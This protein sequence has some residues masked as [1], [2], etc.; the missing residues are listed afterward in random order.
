VGTGIVRTADEVH[1]APKVVPLLDS[2]SVR[3]ATSDRRNPQPTMTPQ[4]TGR[5]RNL[6]ARD[7]SRAWNF[8]PQT[9]PWLD[10]ASVWDHGSHLY[11]RYKAT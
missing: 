5:N 4:L 10:L 11:L 7:S 3:A 6:Y 2:F 9:A 8:I 1:Y